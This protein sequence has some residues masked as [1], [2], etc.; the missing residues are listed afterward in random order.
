MAMVRPGRLRTFMITPR[1]ISLAAALTM[2]ATPVTLASQG[3]PR[4][5]GTLVVSNMS[6]NTATI[7]DAASGRV[8]ATVPTGEGPHEVAISHDGKW[9]LVSNYGVRGAPGNTLTVIDVARAEAARTIT[10]AGHQRPHG[11]AFFPGD[12][13]V[14]V[15][16]ETSQAVLVVDL[17]DGRVTRTLPTRGR[18]SHMVAMTARG[19]RLFSG[20]IADGT[21]SMIDASGRDSARVM[22]VGRAPEGI[23]TTPDGSLVFAGSNR[24]SIVVVIDTRKGTPIDTL[25]GFGL[26]YRIAVTPDS[27]LAIVSDPVRAQVRV[28][29]V[30]D[31]RERFAI[32]IPRD[33]L[34]STAEVPGS[35]SPE[36]VATSRDG[37]W[38][39]VT[40]Q[41]RNRVATIDLE[42]GVIVAYAPTGVWSDGIGVSVIA[43]E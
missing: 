37:R 14:A 19:D 1:L 15:T 39:F 5:R 18:G 41:G 35:P 38:A 8:L 34:V 43:R 36:G 24:D 2:T 32:A 25:R 10:I 33:S 12:T 20:N 9:A 23:A 7:L 4:P 28:F 13:L 31:R 26:P 22:P 40:L 11:M 42:R 21:I 3:T 17:R 16:S 30:S 6:D 29:T 27:R